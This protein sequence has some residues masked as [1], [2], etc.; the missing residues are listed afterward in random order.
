MNKA[1][2]KFLLAVSISTALSLA[3]YFFI[4]VKQPQVL[5]V[6]ASGGLR[7]EFF[8][9]GQGDASMITAPT[10]EQ[11]L[12]DGGPDK[13]IINRLSSALPLS[14]RQIEYVILTH[15]HADHVSGL[16]EVSRRY[17]IGQVI[18]TEASHNASD[19]LEFLELIKEKNIPVLV[20][21]KAQQLIIASTTFDFL[22]PTESFLIDR[23][24]N[25]N[26]TS[27]VF[28]VIYGS[29]SLLFMGD[30]ENEE[31]LAKSTTTTLKADIIK[32]GHHGSSNANDFSFL[33]AVL[34]RYAVVSL[35]A[36]NKFG[37]PHYRVIHSLQKLE[38]QILRTDQS[39]NITFV[40]TTIICQLK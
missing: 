21:D 12:V 26:N 28:R 8:D 27:I 34:P 10:G 4:D 9:V 14:D 19:Y 39:G 7:V 35:G 23:P 6:D 1:L 15:P 20:I 22:A 18:M 30:Y 36:K 38:T 17:E 31:M 2:L 33:K 24:E 16:V 11:I 13:S 25:L 3:V 5:G 37:H 29:S 40:C 32:I